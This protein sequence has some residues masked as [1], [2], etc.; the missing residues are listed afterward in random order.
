MFLIQVTQ[1]VAYLFVIF[2]TVLSYFSVISVVTIT[3][4]CVCCT[5]FRVDIFMRVWYYMLY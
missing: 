5:I 2:L 4:S 3:I 1:N